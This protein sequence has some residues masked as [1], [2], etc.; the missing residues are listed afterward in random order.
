MV[1]EWFDIDSIAMLSLPVTVANELDS[2][3]TSKPWQ[4]R[5]P[6][7]GV[8]VA[9]GAANDR[10]EHGARRRDGEIPTVGTLAIGGCVHLDEINTSVVQSTVTAVDCFEE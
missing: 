4:F 9:A 6:L 1:A 2:N 10:T 8:P 7:R 5:Y 3:L